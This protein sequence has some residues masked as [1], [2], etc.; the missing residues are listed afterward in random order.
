MNS[1]HKFQKGKSL[2]YLYVTAD[3]M[4]LN[5]LPPSIVATL[6]SVVGPRHVDA[7]N[8]GRTQVEDSPLAQFHV[9]YWGVSMEEEVNK[10][11]KSVQDMDIDVDVEGDNN[12]G[13]GD[14]G[15]DG[16]ERKGGEEGE[17]EGE[18]EDEDEE[19]EGKDSKEDEV[20]ID[21]YIEGCYVLDINIVGM[22]SSIWVRAEYIRILD[23]IVKLHNNLTSS[24][25]IEKMSYC[26]IITGQPGIGGFSLTKFIG[27]SLLK[28]VCA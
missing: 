15:E 13:D 4:S 8:E 7:W 9:K 1:S 23:R 28:A 18:D 10:W 5:S 19:K 11:Q 25:R 27:L 21:D 12:N 6:K 3:V 24:N 26:V 20:G 2:G 22:E 16:N 17:G 14:G